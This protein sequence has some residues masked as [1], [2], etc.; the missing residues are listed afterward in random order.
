MVLQNIQDANIIGFHLGIDNDYLFFSIW[1]ICH[2]IFLY[3]QFVTFGT[4]F[5]VVAIFLWF[6]RVDY[7]CVHCLVKEYVLMYVKGFKYSTVFN[8]NLRDSALLFLL[9]HHT[10]IT[11]NSSRSVKLDVWFQR[12]TENCRQLNKLCFH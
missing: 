5:F 4:F 2:S 10:D 12:L 3:L 1:E 8:K 6:L 9:C 7:L 11:T